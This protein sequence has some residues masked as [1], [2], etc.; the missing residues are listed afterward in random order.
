MLETGS[1]LRSIGTTYVLTIA[2]ALIVLAVLAA[3]LWWLPKH[4]TVLGRA[5]R[6]FG[7]IARQRGRAVLIVGLSAALGRAILVPVLGVPVPGVMDEYAHLLAADTFVQGRVTNAPHPM[8]RHFETMH[9][10][11]Q[12]TYQSMYPPAQGAALALG[13]LLAD[14]PWVGVWLSVSIMCAAIWWMLQGWLPAGWAFLGGML[15]V[16]RL[17]LF[18]YWVNSYWGGAL[19]ATGGALVLGALPRLLRRVGVA[20]GF[21]AVLATRH[22]MAPRPVG[23]AVA[24]AGLALLM[25]AALALLATTRPFEGALTAVPVG[26]VLLWATLRLRGAPLRSMLGSVIAPLALALALT[27]AGIGYYNWRGTG[28]ALTMPQQINWQ[29]YR[30][31][32]QFLLLTPNAEPHYRH[33]SMQAFYRWELDVHRSGQGA[34]NAATK[35]AARLRAFWLFFVGAA[36]ALPLLWL[37]WTLRDRRMR[38][39]WVV[40]G[41][42]WAGVLAETWGFPHYWSPLTGA[43]YALM[44]QSM[45]HLRAAGAR[46]QRWGRPAVHGIVAACVVV[47]VARAAAGPL[48]EQLPMQSWPMSALLA[49]A[50]NLER[51]A[52]LD[53]LLRDH[54]SPTRHLVIVRYA[55]SHYE[56]DEWVYNEADIEAARVVWAREMDPASNAALLAHFY[57]RR[58][59]LL[60]PDA[61][62]ELVPYAPAGAAPRP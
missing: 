24:R 34:L 29:T 4:R 28:D 31:A 7:R 2:E 32:H 25:G 8:W 33:P 52:L 40:C 15:C 14:H 20:D 35:A 43:F 37:P 53:R 27:G 60:E 17:G 48:L 30:S 26:V 51:A 50:G 18:G 10:N 54:P 6:F 47:A 12:P 3:A 5:E 58:T 49:D 39:L 16:I 19:A 38:L 41:L 59:W 56:H 57:G 45:R 61:A 22:A 62:R 36:L 42:T 1:L 55:P 23:S 46:R 44:L 13:R 11:Q 9:V 21:G